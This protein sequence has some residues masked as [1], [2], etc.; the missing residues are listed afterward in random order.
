[1]TVGS[2]CETAISSNSPLNALNTAQ[3][4]VDAVLAVE[5]D[6]YR[7]WRGLRPACPVLVGVRGGL[8]FSTSA[9]GP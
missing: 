1:M 5:D 6:V 4:G 2:N 3:K 9:G 8:A 7:G